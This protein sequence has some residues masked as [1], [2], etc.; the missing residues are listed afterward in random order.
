MTQSMQGIKYYLLC[1]LLE[2][3]E[4]VAKGNIQ[5]EWWDPLAGNDVLEEQTRQPCGKPGCPQKTDAV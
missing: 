2:H 1:P 3:E 4:R 5:Q